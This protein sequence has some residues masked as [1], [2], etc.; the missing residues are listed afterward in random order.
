MRDRSGFD[1]DGRG[2]NNR[3]PISFRP[4][5]LL[6]YTNSPDGEGN[7]WPIG[8]P[9]QSP[10]DAHPVALAQVPDLDDAAF[11][12]TG[13]RSFSDADA[14]PDPNRGGWVDNYVDSGSTD[15]AW[16][17]DYNC[18]SFDVLAMTG[19]DIGPS[20]SPGNL[21]GDVAFTLGSGCGTYDYGYGRSR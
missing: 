15:G 1:F 21:Q 8:P 13:Q 3:E 14:D 4:G 20:S 11:T 17:F 10:L 6:T 19:D 9:S 2:A 5:L 16:L 7:V 18:L 12:F